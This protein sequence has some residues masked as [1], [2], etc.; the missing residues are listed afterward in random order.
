MLEYKDGILFYDN[1]MW[2]RVIVSIASFFQQLFETC[3]GKKSLK[4]ISN[5]FGKDKLIQVTKEI[6][7]NNITTSLLNVFTQEKYFCVRNCN[8]ANI[9]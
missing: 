7:L 9:P 6:V 2:D 4:G 3:K 8:K 1:M 5:V